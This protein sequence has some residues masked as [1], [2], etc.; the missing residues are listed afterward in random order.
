MTSGDRYEREPTFVERYEIVRSIKEVYTNFNITARY[1]K[2]VDQCV[3]SHALRNVLL[4]NPALVMNYFRKEGKLDDAKEQ[5]HNFI[6]KPV[7]KIAFDELVTYQKLSGPMDESVL[8]KF[9]ELVFDL[10]KE[11]T[12]WRL[13]ILESAESQ[14]LTFIT[15]HIIG[16][17]NAGT[18]FHEDLVN[19]IVEVQQSD[20]K[21]VPLETLFDFSKDKSSLPAFP[22]STVDL[23][24]DLYNPSLWFKASTILQKHL[25][26]KFVI[27]LVNK[28]VYSYDFE[29]NPIFSNGGAKFH[30]RA[31]YRMIN[32]SASETKALLSSLR[33]KKVTFTPYF[34]AVAL[35]TLQDVVFQC[36]SNKQYSTN[37]SVIVNGR[38]FYP[39]LQEQMKYN[40]AASVCTVIQ[41][42]MPSANSID[43]LAEPIKYISNSISRSLQTRNGFSMAGLL[44]IINLWEILS[45]I[46][47]AESRATME[48]SNIGNKVIKSK[49]LEVEDLIFSQDNGVS[50]HLVFSSV[51]TPVGGINVVIG[52][53]DELEE[54]VI[55]ESN[56]K[57]MDVFAR[58]LKTRLLEYVK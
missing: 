32:V 52:F 37:L 19:E 40:S 53:R 38:R 20:Q 57:A 4:K 49:D 24:P 30:A 13:I 7:Q 11:V 12:L 46:G 45:Q 48:I 54:L 6:R 26:P 15:N 2:Q 36:I 9:N 58:E 51:S 22:K 25:V 23:V 41:K 55:P 3:L 43:G 18:S 39:D 17:A 14:Y 8:K 10:D 5:G 28:Y 16:D 29:Q 1:S 33:S 27:N 47:E 31:H 56:E 35:Q 34:S 42:P 21:D 50:P 44:Q